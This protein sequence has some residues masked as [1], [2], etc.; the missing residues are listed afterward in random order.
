MRVRWV[1][2]AAGAVAL[3]A[4]A[5]GVFASSALAT[6][7]GANGRIIYATG[8]GSTY[9][10]H[11][12]LPSGKG[13]RVIAHSGGQFA[14]SP[15]GRRV[16]FIDGEEGDVY[17]MRADGRDVRQLTFD[18]DNYGPGYAPG[19]AR[20]VFTHTGIT[21]PG[22]TTVRTDGTERR[23]IG[24]N[25]SAS[26]WTP[27]GEIAYLDD[28]G[29]WTMRP[30]GKHRRR[31][32]DLGNDGGYGPMYAPDGSEFLFTRFGLDDSARLLLADGDGSHVREPP[33]PKVSWGFTNPIT[34]SPDGKWL[35]VARRNDSP[36]P[37]LP[38]S[39]NLIRLSLASCTGSRL[40]GRASLEGV[41][42]Q[43]L[44]NG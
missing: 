36:D 18:G 8:R 30:N 38:T 41:D 29:I 9:R 40:V 39:E 15:S 42:W 10:V 35:L 22:I 16:A 1:V 21:D 37:R 32:V 34:Y 4:T 14:W 27:S 5:V 24:E 13:D 23:L 26:G 11:T 7:P 33:C 2:R 6:F 28:R 12:I 17:T 31:L 20:I 19:G 43:A 3:V 44:P 25:L